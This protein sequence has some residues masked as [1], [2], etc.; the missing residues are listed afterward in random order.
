MHQPRRIRK[1]LLSHIGTQPTARLY[2]QSHRYLTRGN[3]QT[4]QVA[5][6]KA[7]IATLDAVKSTLPRGKINT[8]MVRKE[9]S[10]ELC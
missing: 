6:E 4:H 8:Y 1:L 9:T 7:V 10:P 2:N 5:S 3:Y